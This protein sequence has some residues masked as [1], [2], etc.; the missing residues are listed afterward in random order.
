MYTMAVLELRPLSKPAI[1]V[2]PMA[3]MVANIPEEA[4]ITTVVEDA[5]TFSARAGT[6][7]KVLMKEAIHH[8]ERKRELFE[9]LRQPLPEDGVL[10][11]VHVDPHHVAY[12][13]FE[14]ALERCRT[15]FA[16]PDELTTLLEQAGFT[17]E[18]EL[19]TYHHRVPRDR[20]FKMVEGCYMSV[21][22]SFDD[23]ELRAGLDEMAERYADEPVLEFPETFDYL[24][25]TP[26]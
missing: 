6:Y 2:D 14:A 5:V 20:Y 26:A 1:G 19:F 7:D 16:D 23:D 22:T 12:P 3:D 21:L 15:T 25:A 18:A 8:I 24:T 17:V 13:L 10:L 9:N 4:P 11:L